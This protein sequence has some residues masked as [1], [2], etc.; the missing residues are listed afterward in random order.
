MKKN[1]KNTTS[2]F[3]HQL[4][5]I[6]GIQSRRRQFYFLILPL[7][8]II[9]ISG[10]CTK[11]LTEDLKG[12]F[13]SDTYFQNDKQAIQAINGT[14]NA[15]AFT[16]SDNAIW[17]FGDVAS[18]D[19]V[20]GGNEGDQAEIIYI[21]QFTANSTTGNLLMKPLPAPIL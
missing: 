1:L 21:D 4:G 9:A 15:I 3:M 13:S 7:G 2:A 18:D 20:K 10:A 14:Y 12:E 19:A 17:V 6:A 16:N 11:F 5:N 8:F